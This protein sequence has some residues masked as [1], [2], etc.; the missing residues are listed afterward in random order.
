MVRTY[1]LTHIALAVSDLERSTR[2][3]RELFGMVEVYR[4]GDFV[5]LQTPG[6]RDVLVLEHEPE[7]AGGAGGVRHFGFRLVDPGDIAA[8][9]ESVE[10]ADGCGSRGS[11]ALGSRTSSRSTRMATNSRYCTSSPRK[12]I[13]RTAPGEGR[14]LAEA[15]LQALHHRY[16]V[17]FVSMAVFSSV[18][19]NRGRSVRSGSIETSS[20]DVE[21]RVTKSTSCSLSD[22]AA[23]EGD[24]VLRVG[25]ERISG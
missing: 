21:R 23:T 25:R 10:R 13:R 5:Q 1:G 11:S 4:Q 6:S 12:S 18:V 22:E 9:A 19:D 7:L 15:L 20:R 17:E 3:Y 24:A 16:P 8:A 2:F 14:P